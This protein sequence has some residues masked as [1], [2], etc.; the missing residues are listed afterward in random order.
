M[1]SKYLN[2]QASNFGNE[3]SLFAVEDVTAAITL[4]EEDSGKYYTLDAAGGAYV[5]TLPSPSAGIRYD[6]VVQEDTP[7]NAITIT[8]TGAIIYGRVLEGEVDT[9]DDAPGSSGA[10]GQTSFIVGTQANRGDSFR[11]VCDGTYWYAQGVS[12]LDGSFTVA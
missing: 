7:S 11:L 4:T 3:H 9:S 6:F 12:A 2:E 10:T 8:A 1:K 5:V